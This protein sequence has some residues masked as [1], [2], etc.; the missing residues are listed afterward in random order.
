MSFQIYAH[1]VV[2]HVAGAAGWDTEGLTFAMLLAR[3][4]EL[5][6][7]C[8]AL[9]TYHPTIPSQGY[10][11]RLRPNLNVQAQLLDNCPPDALP[12]CGCGSHR[13]VV[14]RFADGVPPV[15]LSY[16]LWWF[17]LDAVILRLASGYAVRLRTASVLRE[18]VGW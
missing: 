7:A 6:I 13:L 16:F 3:L 8:K 15:W 2:R 14:P 1:D 12:F 5:F 4:A 11:G 17:P 18:N 10:F 9:D